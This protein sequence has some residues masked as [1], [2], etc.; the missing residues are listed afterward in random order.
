MSRWKVLVMVCV[1]AIPFS[2]T[3]QEN[4]KLPEQVAQILRQADQDV[5]AARAK[6]VSRLQ[7]V[8]E[9]EMRLG[10]LDAANAIKAAIDQLKS[11]K[12]QTLE[13]ALSPSEVAVVPAGSN[14]VGRTVRIVLASDKTLGLVVDGPLV[15]VAKLG[16][17]NAAASLFKVHEGMDNK[18]MISFETGAAKDQFLSGT[19][20]RLCVKDRSQA[21]PRYVT[22]FLKK[23]T[24]GDMLMSSRYPANAITMNEKKELWMSGSPSARK[25]EFMLVPQ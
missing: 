25:S 14:L 21:D 23:G 18:L 3:A 11:S 12:S 9:S 7:P 17:K 24:R 13:A 10:H 20:E 15:N 5:A 19:D 4:A 2:G 16:P 8:L 6:A 22:F 1:T